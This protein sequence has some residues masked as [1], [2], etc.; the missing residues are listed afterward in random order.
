[1]INASSLYFL[2]V[3]DIAFDIDEINTDLKQQLDIVAT[4][5]GMAVGEFA[6]QL[7]KDKEDEQELREARQVEAEKAAMSVSW[8]LRSRAVIA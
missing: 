3:S 2:L 5:Y 4:T 8:N 1:M 6:E 7:R